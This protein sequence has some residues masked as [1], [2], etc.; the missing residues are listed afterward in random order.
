[1]ASETVTVSRLQAM[2]ALGAPFIAVAVAWGLL[3]GSVVRAQETA[4]RAEVRALHAEEGFNSVNVRLER[5]QT[6]LERIE[7][8]R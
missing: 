6:V 4:E 1:M 7:R 2:V 8:S 5:I 3:Q